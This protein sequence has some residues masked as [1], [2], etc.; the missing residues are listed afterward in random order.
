MASAWRLR[1]AGALERACRRMA[2]DREMCA[3]VACVCVGCR[4]TRRE[5]CRVG[6]LC[7]RV[8]RRCVSKVNIY[9]YK[10]QNLLFSHCPASAAVFMDF[11]DTSSAYEKLKFSWQALLNRA[12]VCI[13]RLRSSR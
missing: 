1:P 5:A 10:A 13:S 6:V 3:C 4:V 8:G 9:I 11:T 12:R 2:R 7:L